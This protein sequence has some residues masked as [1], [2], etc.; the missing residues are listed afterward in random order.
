VL[1]E[2]AAMLHTNLRGDA[3]AP[4]LKSP[5]YFRQYVTHAAVANGALPFYWY[6]G[7]MIDRRNNHAVLAPNLLD[8]L[9]KGATR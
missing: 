8:A 6:T 4:H 3:L 1:G 7:R 5:I 2:Y 9:V